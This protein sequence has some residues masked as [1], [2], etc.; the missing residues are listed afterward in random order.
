MELVVGDV[1][2]RVDEPPIG[3]VGGGA[4]NGQNRV[5]VGVIE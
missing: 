1:I 2:L 5:D 4:R 3:V